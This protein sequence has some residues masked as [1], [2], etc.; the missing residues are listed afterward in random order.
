MIKQWLIQFA[1]LLFVHAA[2]YGQNPNRCPLIVEAESGRLGS[3]FDILQSGGFQYITITSD[4]DE[5]SGTSNFPGANR[6]AVYEVSFPDTGIYNLFARIRVGQNAFDDDSFFYGNNFG[7]K[8]CESAGE[9]VVCNGLASAGFS[10][11]NET[12]YE[13]GAE[14]SN[15]WKW[16]NLSLNSYQGSSRNFILNDPEALVR[17]FS[18]GAREN[19]FDIDKFAFGKSGL[20]FTVENLDRMQE[21]S[22]TDPNETVEPPARVPL[23]LAKKKFLGCGLETNQSYRFE[24]Y[25]NQVTP[26][27]GGKWGSVEYSRDRMNWGALDQAYRMGLGYSGIRAGQGLFSRIH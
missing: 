19:G 10:D 14:G 20:Y 7:D 5:T 25:W 4:Y 23:A 2:V 15:T 12:V 22:V 18:I 13:A 1:L 11:E 27:N 17:I 26:G 21:G 8:N 9:W 3:E 6:T 16:V 24:E